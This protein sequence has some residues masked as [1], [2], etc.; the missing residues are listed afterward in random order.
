MPVGRLVEASRQSPGTTFYPC[1]SLGDWTPN[2]AYARGVMTTG[3][4][5]RPICQNGGSITRSLHG[6][7]TQLASD[8]DES[9]LLLRCLG[10]MRPSTHFQARGPASGP[11]PWS[12]EKMDEQSPSSSRLRLERF[13]A[14]S[15]GHHPA[16]QVA[17]KGDEQTTGQSHDANPPHALATLGKA[18][19]EPDAE[20]RVGLIA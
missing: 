16:L 17:P 5:K 8:R 4:L 1:Q 12:A 18:G 9:H 15:I 19:V 20:S 2:P 11:P 7:F 6:R 10:P 14:S 3:H 13:Q